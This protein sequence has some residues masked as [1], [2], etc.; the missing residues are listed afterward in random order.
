MNPVLINDSRLQ[1]AGPGATL[2]IGYLSDLRK[3][4]LLSAFLLLTGSHK[5]KILGIF[6]SSLEVMEA[7]PD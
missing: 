4:L 1:G 5:L 2:I 7:H 3:M 6:T